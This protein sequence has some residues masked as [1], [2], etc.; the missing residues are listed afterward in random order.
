MAVVSNLDACELILGNS[1]SRFSG[2]TSTM[3]QTLVYQQTLMPLRVL[4]HHHLVDDDLHVGFWQL[5]RHCRKPL[6]DGRWRV[7]HARRNDEMIQAIL[8]RLLGVKIKIVFTSTAQRHHSLFS[9]WLMSKMDAVISTCHAAA[10]Y[11]RQAPA[12][13]I[14]HGIRTDLFKPAE[15]KAALWRS[16]GFGGQIGLAIFGRVRAQKGVHLFVRACIEVLNENTGY[17]AI[18]VGAIDNKNR[19]FVDSLKREIMAAGLEKRIVFTGEQPFAKIPELF[20]AVSLVA[21]LSD[22]EGFGLTVLEAMSSEAAVLASEAGA[23]P[24]IVNEGVEG[25]LVPINDQQ[26]VTAK[27]ASVLA[28]P[29]RLAE[30]GVEGRTRVL[31]SYTVEREASDLCRFYRSLQSSGL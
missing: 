14:P 20:R 13:I 24:E 7:F 30:M 4:G 25:M 6:S 18:I 28:Q 9:R 3:L 8:L 21:A 16:L 23:W 15:D 1:N 11:L 26:A 31:T 19:A 12:A 17:T 27:L 29:H 10:R 22:N 2:V 5:V